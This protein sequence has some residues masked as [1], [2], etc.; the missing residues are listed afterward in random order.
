MKPLCE[1]FADF[2]YPIEAIDFFLDAEKKLNACPD[3]AAL[4]ERQLSIY[5]STD[6]FELSELNADVKSAARLSGISERTLL[7]ILYAKMTFHMHDLYRKKG[8]AE[9]IWHDSVRDL[10]FKNRECHDVKGEWGLFTDWFQGFLKLRL[11]ALG[12]LQLSGRPI[13]SD[14]RTD[15]PPRHTHRAGQDDRALD[16]HPVGRQTSSRGCSHLAEKGL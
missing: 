7:F 13:Q 9:D 2:D 3:A 10:G 15:N 1:F 4:L 12:R 8:I 16:S 6:S 5:E 14:R 11:F